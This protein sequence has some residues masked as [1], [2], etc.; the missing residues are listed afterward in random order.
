MAGGDIKALPFV[1]RLQASHSYGIVLALILVSFAFSA[2][3]PDERWSRAVSVVL[4][5]VTL[6]VAL[7]TSGAH[8][9]V[10]QLALLAV[11]TGFAIS[12]VSLLEG[13]NISLGL[14]GLISGLMVALV[15]FAIVRGMLRMGEV[16]R[17]TI[18]GALSVYLLV[19]MFFAFLFNGIGLI[20]PKPFFAQ[21]T[22]GTTPDYLYYSFTT[23]TTTGYGDLTAAGQLGRTFSNIEQLIGQAYLVTIVAFI[24][25]RLRPRRARPHSEGDVRP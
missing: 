10:L 8:E 17:E 7:W 15:P 9:P 2:A 3:A 13:S 21:G 14:V 19:G 1:R 16:R 24:I 18:F 23:L 6:L 22:D 12:T 20:D 11:L 5:G 25:S 4:H